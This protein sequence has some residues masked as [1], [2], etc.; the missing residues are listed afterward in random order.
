MVTGKLCGVVGVVCGILVCS[1][2]LDRL[3]VWWCG[4]INHVLGRD[5]GRVFSP[6]YK[7]LVRHGFLFYSPRFYAASF[8]V[9]AVHVYELSSLLSVVHVSMPR[10]FSSVEAVHVYDLSSLLSVVHVSMPRFFSSLL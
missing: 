5:S 1:V 2:V 4:V 8:S 3:G 6:S 7:L 9:V 10:F